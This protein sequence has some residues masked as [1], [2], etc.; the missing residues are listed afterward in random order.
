MKE[1]SIKDY[2]NGKL[3]IHYNGN[4]YIKSKDEIK[5]GLEL[6]NIYFEELTDEL[7]LQYM[8]LYY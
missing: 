6:N 8:E 2:S 1:F 5:Q 7:V 4:N 3:F